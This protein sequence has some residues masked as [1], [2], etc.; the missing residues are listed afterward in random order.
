MQGLVLARRQVP[1]R[2]QPR[3]VRVR[4]RVRARA[5]ARA[6]ARNRNRNRNRNRLVQYAL[7]TARR[8]RRS[9]KLASL[10]VPANPL[11]SAPDIP[12]GDCF[13]VRTN[14]KTRRCIYTSRPPSSE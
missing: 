14:A 10:S 13:R 12:L 6:R 5:R 7:P 9:P 11:S 1:A 2:A 8:R 4:V 3:G